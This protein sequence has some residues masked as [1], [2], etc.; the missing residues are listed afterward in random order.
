[1]SLRLFAPAN[2]QHGSDIAHN[3]DTS[4][5]HKTDEKLQKVKT[6]HGNRM[7]ASATAKLFV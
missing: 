5:I 7:S 3:S 2:T 1:M 6:W 4:L